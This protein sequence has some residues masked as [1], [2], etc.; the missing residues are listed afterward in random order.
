MIHTGLGRAI[1]APQCFLKNK[2]AGEF[3]DHYD[4]SIP[5]EETDQREQI[6]SADLGAS[7]AGLDLGG[8]AGRALP[9]H[10]TARPKSSIGG[11]YEEN[12]NRG[13]EG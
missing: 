9:Q 7:L 6:S 1:G 11:F 10:E 8:G 5:V 13:F 4:L 2:Q 12:K 3:A